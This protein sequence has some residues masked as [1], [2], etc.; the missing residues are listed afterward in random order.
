MLHKAPYTQTQSTQAQSTPLQAS[1]ANSTDRCASSFWDEHKGLL[2]LLLGAVL[3]MGFHLF[4]LQSNTTEPVADHH[5]VPRAMQPLHTLLPQRHPAVLYAQMVDAQLLANHANKSTLTAHT[6]PSYAH[7]AL[8]DATRNSALAPYDI[9]LFAPRSSL[10]RTDVAAPAR[11]SQAS[12]TA[13]SL[14]QTIEQFQHNNSI[15][16]EKA[17]HTSYSAQKSVALG[18]APTGL[19]FKISKHAPALTYSDAYSDA[20][21]DTPQPSH[22]VIHAPLARTLQLF[23]VPQGHAQQI[24]RAD[25]PNAIMPIERIHNTIIVNLKTVRLQDTDLRATD[26]EASARQNAELDTLNSTTRSSAS[27]ETNSVALI[28]Y[29]ETDYPTRLIISAANTE[30][31]SHA[32]T[33]TQRSA[34]PVW[35][36]G[37]LVMTLI[38]LAVTLRSRALSNTRS[39]AT[40]PDPKSQ[41]RSSLSLLALTTLTLLCAI[42]AAIYL[43]AW[44]KDPI[45]SLFIGITLLWALQ[46]TAYLKLSATMIRRPWQAPLLIIG[47]FVAVHL[48]PVAALSVARGPLLLIAMSL[49]LGHSAILQLRCPHPKTGSNHSLSHIAERFLIRGLPAI[50]LMLAALSFIAWLL[51]NSLVAPLHNAM[52]PH[53]AGPW[54]WLTISLALCGLGHAVAIALTVRQQQLARAE[55][56][57]NQAK[58][59]N[60]N[61]TIL[62]QLSQQLTP[63]ET[64]MSRS[65]GSTMRS[66]ENVPSRVNLSTIGESQHSP[67]EKVAE[68]ADIS[69]LLD[70]E[71]Q[72]INAPLHIE[73]W[74]EKNTNAWTQRANRQNLQLIISVKP[75]TPSIIDADAEKLTHMVQSILDISLNHALTGNIILRLDTTEAESGDLLY[76][77]TIEDS[78]STLPEALIELLQTNWLEI[79]AK[80]FD[81]AHVKH[82]RLLLAHRWLYLAQGKLAVEHTPLYGTRFQITFKTTARKIP[83]VA[84]AQPT[85]PIKSASTLLMSY[86]AEYATTMAE[87]A[88]FENNHMSLALSTKQAMRNLQQAQTAA[89]SFQALIVDFSRD[90]ESLQGFIFELKEQ[91]EYEDTPIIL[92]THPQQRVDYLTHL[93][94]AVYAISRPSDYKSLSTA[95]NGIIFQSNPNLKNALKNASHQL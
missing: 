14:A 33:S 28:G 54:H 79:I 43:F 57:A 76:R 42:L 93:M 59:K 67:F 32:I 41:Y 36:T 24:G 9:S 37:I 3:L 38:A 5:A 40:L 16:F 87:Q 11:H 72:W 56:L 13:A 74:I 44:P 82:A 90:A 81:Q 89:R 31:D 84:V 71:A 18:P 22:L 69:A 21:S 95:V 17:D 20:Y 60:M 2:Q 49:L 45:P 73:Q 1:L 51:P 8:R 53:P 4:W 75:N 7:H 78:N 77:L 86:D 50:G 88:N 47:F 80:P 65:A 30:R 64:Q 83:T 52:L 91:P 94:R 46:R 25:T 10:N 61:R 63:P 70:E 35:L 15:I 55:A 26:L 62:A 68:Y 34:L 19:F 12:P 48:L 85:T 66:E 6:A 92:L 58:I 27:L 39:N 29:I 23:S